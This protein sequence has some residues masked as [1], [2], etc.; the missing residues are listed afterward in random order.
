M[1]YKSKLYN[2]S[3]WGITNLGPKWLT[4]ENL[5][6]SDCQWNFKQWR[7]ISFIYLKESTLKELAEKIPYCFLPPFWK[8]DFKRMTLCFPSNEL[9]STVKGFL[10]N[11]FIWWVWSE[12][13]FLLLCQQLSSYFMA[14]LWRTSEDQNS[15]KKNKL[16]LQTVYST[17]EANGCLLRATLST[18]TVKALKLGQTSRTLLWVDDSTSCTLAGADEGQD[19]LSPII[20][21]FDCYR[22]SFASLYK[23]P[24]PTST[25]QYTFI[26]FVKASRK[27]L[28]SSISKPPRTSA[29]PWVAVK[30][31]ALMKHS[32]PMPPPRAQW[33]RDQFWLPTSS[34][35]VKGGKLFS[36]SQAGQDTQ[37]R[38]PSVFMGWEALFEGTCNITDAVIFW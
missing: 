36:E 1:I 32:Q 2:I 35:A 27:A 24:S 5:Q 7:Y 16:T 9:K 22:S 38:S 11:C 25:V 4:T 15:V 6:L 34:W 23:N 12:L 17:L 33:Q 18:V 14:L 30:H 3:L 13:S 26:Y 19:A 28:Q 37:T 8:Y 31:R 21:V 10:L 29:D 20:W